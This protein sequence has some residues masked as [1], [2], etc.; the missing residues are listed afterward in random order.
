M[1]YIKSMDRNELMMASLDMLV[2]P[3]SIVRIIDAFV[4]TPFSNDER[5][6]RRIDLISEIENNG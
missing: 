1:P 2:E 6:I 4:D 3:D 5:H